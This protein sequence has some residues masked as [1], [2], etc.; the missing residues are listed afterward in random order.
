MLR[1][2]KALLK[3]I[4]IL[5]QDAAATATSAYVDT[6]AGGSF[7]FLVNVEAFAFD[8]ANNLVFSVLGKDAA[9]DVGAAIPA[10]DLVFVL[11]GVVVP[12]GEL[13]TALAA[14]AVL[15]VHYLGYKKL[16][17]LD[18]V[19]TGVVTAGLGVTGIHGH[20]DLAPPRAGV[21]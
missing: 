12:N 14:N 5:L 1:S 21:V 2:L 15:E 7:T 19:K 4:F 6:V 20:L 18:I 11:G 3:P 17:A 8:N 13:K 9:A 16:V 10:E